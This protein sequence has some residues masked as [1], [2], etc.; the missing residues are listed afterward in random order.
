MPSTKESSTNQI[1]VKCNIKAAL[2]A[3]QN[4]INRNPNASE[5]TKARMLS[6]YRSGRLKGA[7]VSI[8]KSA[9]SFL[10]SLEEFF[11]LGLMKEIDRETS[12]SH[13]HRETK[14]KD[15]GNIQTVFCHWGVNLSAYIAATCPQL[16]KWARKL[17]W[18]SFDVRRDLCSQ[19][20]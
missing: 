3:Y 11:W 6:L 1:P 13:T 18:F 19:S 5:G 9:P 17:T 7:S 20:C 2:N 10:P 14:A 16:S 4:C 15:S 8:T 12:L